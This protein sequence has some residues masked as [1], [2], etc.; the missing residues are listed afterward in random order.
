LSK[1]LGRSSRIET[2]TLQFAVDNGSPSFAAIKGYDLSAL[3]MN[4]RYGVMPE[5]L[6]AV[7]DKI[8]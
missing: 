2:G 1:N 7:H 8:S 3:W 4:C 6:L 5:W